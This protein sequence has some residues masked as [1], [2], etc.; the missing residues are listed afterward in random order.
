MNKE[1]F[2]ALISDLY[3][4]LVA[5]SDDISRKYDEDWEDPRVETASLNCDKGLKLY[6]NLFKEI[7]YDAR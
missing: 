6:E 1:R 3:W 4:N 2:E 7:G 5:I